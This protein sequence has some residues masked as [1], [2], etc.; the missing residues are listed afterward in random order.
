MNSIVSA[1]EMRRL[2]ERCFASGAASSVELMQIAGNGCADLILQFLA[3]LPACRRIVVFAGSGN[4]GGDGVVIAHTLARKQ[5][6][7]VILALA[8]PGKLSDSS[9][10]FF[11]RID[12]R[13]QRISTWGL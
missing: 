4:N 11:A 10:H 13:H 5:E 12:D 6:L 2:E 7:P 9:A 1:D 8:K 3:A